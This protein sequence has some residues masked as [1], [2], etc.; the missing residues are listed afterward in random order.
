MRPDDVSKRSM[1]YHNKVS[2]QH[3][4]P[5]SLFIFSP[6]RASSSSLW[7]HVVWS[8]TLWCLGSMSLLATPQQQTG[9]PPCLSAR[10]VGGAGCHAGAAGTFHPA[11]S[12]GCAAAPAG[13]TGS[14]S[15]PS[16]ARL[17]P[18]CWWWCGSQGGCESPG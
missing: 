3:A 6:V 12:A 11:R 17:P 18:G 16:A 9:S 15:P 1:W 5:Q 14:G 13:R 2:G 7:A 4:V 8:V 10:P